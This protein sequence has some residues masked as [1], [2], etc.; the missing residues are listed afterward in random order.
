MLHGMLANV[1]MP[2]SQRWGTG[3]HPVWDTG[4]AKTHRILH[5]VEHMWISCSD[6]NNSKYPLKSNKLIWLIKM[7]L[8]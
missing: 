4:V 7:L 8:Q 3:F 1:S 2:Q 6:S 5:P